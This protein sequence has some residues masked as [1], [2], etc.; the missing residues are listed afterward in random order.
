MAKPCKFFIIVPFILVWM[1][2]R[3]A[4]TVSYKGAWSRSCYRSLNVT[5]AQ[6]LQPTFFQLARLLSDP[7]ATSTATVG[8]FIRVWEWEMVVLKPSAWLRCREESRLRG[9]GRRG[10]LYPPQHLQTTFSPSQPPFSWH[11]PLPMCGRFCIFTFWS[12]FCSGMW[13]WSYVAVSTGQDLTFSTWS[14][15]WNLVTVGT[16]QWMNKRTA[17]LKRTMSTALGKQ[18]QSLH[19]HPQE[20][21]GSF[22]STALGKQG[23]TSQM[24]AASRVS[25]SHL[26]RRS[27]A[28]RPCPEIT[29]G[30]WSTGL[31]FSRVC[32][33]LKPQ[34]LARSTKLHLYYLEAAT[35]RA[36]NPSQCTVMENKLPILLNSKDDNFETKCHF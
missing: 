27:R 8:C 5:C 23:Q 7:P 13:L 33:A 29:Q 14:H 6:K 31:P 9:K 11:L 32:K 3:A 34:C 24:A 35:Y 1:G 20:S 25:P 12:E 18:G 22:M 2:H 16:F 4:N 10:D 15:I 26:T 28:L 21:R 19:Q 36:P 17:K 30:T